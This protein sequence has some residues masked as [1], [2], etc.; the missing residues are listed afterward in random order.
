L[1]ATKST[2]LA[3]RPKGWHQVYDVRTTVANY[4]LA[5]GYAIPI[6]DDTPEDDDVSERAQARE[7]DKGRFAQRQREARGQEMV[8]GWWTVRGRRSILGARGN[9]FA[10]HAPPVSSEVAA[11]NVASSMVIS[12][13]S[14][15]SASP[16]SPPGRQHWEQWGPNTSGM[17]R[18]GPTESGNNPGSRLQQERRT[19]DDSGSN[20]T[21]RPRRRP[22]A[23]MKLVIVSSLSAFL[24]VAPLQAQWVK[25]PPANIPRTADGKPNASAPAPRGPDGK[26]DLSGIWRPD[27]QYNGEPANFAA[28]LH[29][30][31]IAFQPWAKALY[32]ER[33]TGAQSRND[34]SAQCLPQG[35]PRIDTVQGCGKLFRLPGS[36]PSC[37]RRSTVSGARSFLMAGNPRTMRHP[38]GSDTRQG[39]GTATCSSWTRKVSTERLGWIY[40]ASHP[41]D[42][43]HVIER[44]HRTDF[45]HTEIHITIDDPK[46]IPD[47]GR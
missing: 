15:R 2:S 7:R 21:R 25:V 16:G 12:K 42:P 39:S 10:R 23:N 33:K 44:F 5:S 11:S 35:V 46:P 43:L 27:N 30:D 13:F 17:E 29:V 32:D 26:P 14:Y 34:P 9:P 38:H 4:L 18:V 8:G 3:R 40:W 19:C 6:A 24:L 41:P 31:D 22:R 45:G 1:T 36:L 37:I 47:L 28:N 20:L